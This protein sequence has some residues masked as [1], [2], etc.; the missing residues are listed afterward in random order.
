[1]KQI[2]DVIA[3]RPPLIRAKPPNSAFNEQIANTISFMG[4]KNDRWRYW[5]GRLKRFS[6]SEIHD[7]RK[8]AETGRNKKALFNYLIKK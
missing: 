7:L 1:M 6:P 8:K 4:E 3:S 5:C 2:K